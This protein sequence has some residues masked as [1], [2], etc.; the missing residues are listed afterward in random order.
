MSGPY[1]YTPQVEYRN[2]PYLAPYYTQTASPF[3]PDVSL[4]SSPFSLPGDLPTTPV[5]SP[6]SPFQPPHTAGF[7]APEETTFIPTGYLR[8]RR[9]SWPG[10]VDPAAFTRTPRRQR[11]RS[12]GEPPSP[13]Q[14]PTTINEYEWPVPLSPPI[15]AQ[16]P[17]TQPQIRLHP[18]LS[19]D[20]RSDFV[21][22]LSWPSFGPSRAV[23]AQ[24]AHGRSGLVL[25]S[26][27]EL[28][29]T[30]THPAVYRIRITCDYIPQWPITLEYNPAMAT[31]SGYPMTAPPIKLGDVLSGIWNAMQM[32]IS[33]QDWARLDPRL[34][35]MVTRA[36]TERCAVMPDNE[37]GLSVRNQGVKRLDFLLGKVWFKGL[38]RVSDYEYK[39]ILA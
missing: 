34:R 15:Y 31:G 16:V 30:A 23:S 13:F 9:P 3:I 39:M 20:A 5:L 32:R 17:L 4:N 11:T 2:S 33:H 22:N 10:P 18:W 28:N 7:P 19:A 21:F 38:K 12:F 14:P 26:D 24:F 27:E 1:V 6:A 29:T 8:T 35:H 36:F 37:V 25:L